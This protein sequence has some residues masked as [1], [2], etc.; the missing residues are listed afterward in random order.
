L[1][2]RVWERGRATLSL[3]SLLVLI[4]S[5]IPA[6][7]ST[8]L[9]IDDPLAEVNYDCIYPN[10]SI[11]ESDINSS[12]I[13]ILPSDGHFTLLLHSEPL[14]VMQDPKS[15]MDNMTNYAYAIIFG[16]FLVFLSGGVAG[17]FLSTFFRRR[18]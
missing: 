13:C 10:G 7:A 18:G 3:L 4:F 1:S 14:R 12:E 2:K 17:T 16:A 15:F 11:Y 5:V 8:S 9:R 6:S